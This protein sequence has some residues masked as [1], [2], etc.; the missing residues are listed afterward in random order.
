MSASRRDNRRD[1][2][3]ESN[4][5]RLR[6]A[7]DEAQSPK[8]PVP[9]TSFEPVERS[10]TLDAVSPS[11][12]NYSMATVPVQNDRHSNQLV[13]SSQDMGYIADHSVLLSQ[14]M[15]PPTSISVLLQKTSSGTRDAILRVTQADIMPTIV[16]RDALIDLFFE[17]VYYR[18]P[19]LEKEELIGPD[20]SVLLVQ[21]VCLVGS[22]VRQ[23]S[24]ASN[25]VRTCSLYEKIKTL[26]YL[27]YEPDSLVV[28]KAMCLLSTWSP[29]P[30][31]SLS[32][33]SPWHW[34]GA[35]IRLA[36]QMGLH[37]YSLYSHKPNATNRQRIWWLLWIAD[38]LQSSC[39]GRPATIKSADFDVPPP[40]LSDFL[41]SNIASKYFIHSVKLSVIL[42]RIAEHSVL[43]TVLETTDMD[44]LA[45]SLC[46]WIGDLPEDIRLFDSS[47]QRMP[48]SH[49]I[50]ELHIMYLSTVILLQDLQVQGERRSPTSVLSIVASSCITRLYEEIYYRED[51]RF[52]LPIHSFY[53]MVAAVPQIYYTPQDAAKDA[54]RQEE[55]DIINSVVEQLQTRFGGASTVARNI[56]RLKDE[57]E[58]MKQ[59]GNPQSDIRHSSNA[60][61]SNSVIENHALE[62]FPFASSLSCDIPDLLLSREH[63]MQMAIDMP[64][65]VDDNLL[66][67][68]FDESLPFFNIFGLNDCAIDVQDRE[69]GV[70][71]NF[72]MG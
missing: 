25:L 45:K 24:N 69:N 26:I 61:W 72:M 31:D 66:A 70:D 54:T 30:S 63:D 27:R 20:A 32:L 18:Y 50:S 14:G 42:D 39:F 10:A 52:M 4:R 37:R 59:Q 13:N 44:D 11:I 49:A 12:G 28:L 57:S 55:L 43:R 29:Y 65:P 51:V 48:Y 17:H 15:S 19:I 7:L 47:N 41:A 1:S 64:L 56:S 22:L 16:L 8:E 67:W 3:R 34:T 21:A 71:G 35:A 46:S 38:K 2:H 58:R 6:K 40:T 5:H 68:S 33:D 23:D 36:V 53:C 62:L 60:I 9:R